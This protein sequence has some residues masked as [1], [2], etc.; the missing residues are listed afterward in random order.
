MIKTKQTKSV[1]YIHINLLFTI[2]ILYQIIDS[3]IIYIFKIIDQ[4][5]F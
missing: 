4:F 1:I 5:K 3:F 2:F